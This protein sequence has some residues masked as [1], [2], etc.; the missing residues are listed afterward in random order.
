M[1]NRHALA[2]VK[3]NTELFLK[4]GD[5]VLTDRKA[6]AASRTIKGEGGNDDLPARFQAFPNA[7]YIRIALFLLSEEMKHCAVVPN[8]E[9]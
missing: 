2:Y 5:V 1:F 8:I 7:V 3:I 9:S 6:A 4:E